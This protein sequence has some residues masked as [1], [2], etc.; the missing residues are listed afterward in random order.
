MN[1]YEK[2]YKC[3]GCYNS[4][5]L[6]KLKCGIIVCGYKYNKKTNKYNQLS[7]HIKQKTLIKYKNN[8]N[9]ILYGCFN[10]LKYNKKT[11]NFDLIP[12]KDYDKY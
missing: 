1:N 11:D 4:F 6:T 7:P 5:I 12:L 2:M 3:S 9:Y 10:K 8:K